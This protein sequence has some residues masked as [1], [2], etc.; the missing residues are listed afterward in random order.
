[1]SAPYWVDIFDEIVT[2]VRN[3]T[4]KPAALDTD[5]PFYMYGHPLEIIDTLAKKDKHDTHKFNKYP[6][7]A[8]FQDF[9][10]TMGEHQ[11]TQSAVN[12][13]NIVICMNTSPDYTAEDRYTNTFKTVLYPLYDLLIKHILKSKWFRNIDPG[14]V[15]HQKIDRLFWG[16]SGLYGNESN[17][18]NDYID[19]IEIQNLALELR[20]KQNCTTY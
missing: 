13:M 10:E 1:M 7:I 19:A 20:L 3:D 2:D 16:R 14:L 17:I 4:D 11:A 12:D 9:T 5:E 6:L 8:L 18:F 15:P